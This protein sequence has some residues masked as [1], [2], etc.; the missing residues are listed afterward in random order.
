[1]IFAYANAQLRSV[2]QATR[3]IPIVFIGASDP[4]GAGY[5]AS[6]AQPG[7]SELSSWLAL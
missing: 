6:F 2:S 7:G 4:V 5:A 3:T 1:V